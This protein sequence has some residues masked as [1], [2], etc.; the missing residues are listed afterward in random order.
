MGLRGYI[1]DLIYTAVHLSGA[2]IL[3]AVG[4]AGLAY[5]LRSAGWI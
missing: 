3:L 4:L 2:L 1:A 5:G